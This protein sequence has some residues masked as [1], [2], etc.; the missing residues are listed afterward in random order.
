MCYMNSTTIKAIYKTNVD[1]L[2]TY[3]NC[4]GMADTK[5]Q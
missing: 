2:R 3:P 1:N 5:C 4:F